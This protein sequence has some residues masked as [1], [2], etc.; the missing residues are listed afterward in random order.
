MLDPATG[1]RRKIIIFTEPRDT[2][3]Y[4]HQK[5]RPGI[6]DP[7]A[8]VVIHG[9]IAR[10]ARR[11]A[12][13]AFN[14]DPVVRVM[15]ANDAAGEGVNLQRGAHLMVNYDLPW[16]P[17]RLEQRFGRIHRIG[18]TE[19]CHLWNLCA[20]IDTNM[21]ALKGVSGTTGTSGTT[22]TANTT[23]SDGRRVEDFEE[24]AA[25]V[26]YEAAVPRNWAEGFARILRGERFKGF[27]EKTWQQL[28]DDG[29]QF[30]DSWGGEADRLGW[31]A[32]DVFGVRVAKPSAG[33][34]VVGFA[35]LIRGG[36]VVSIGREH[37]TIRTVGG[38]TLTYFRRTKPDA[39]GIW[40][41]VEPIADIAC[42]AK[43]DL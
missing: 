5:I 12:I 19:V 28:I 11:A 18:Q 27:D 30:L 41:L 39:I 16:N 13:A 20:A 15:I 26:E 1:L 3:E 14:S 7:A 6:G 2:L 25:I 31:S 42:D 8:V 35:L 37:A 24:R 43:G 33:F 9:G 4:L 23:V 21:V 36:E 22:R 34:D 40:D 10:E 32:L 29:G 38:T 17:N